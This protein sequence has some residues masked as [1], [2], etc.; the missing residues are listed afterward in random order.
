M[1]M[2]A[3]TKLFVT[4]MLVTVG[5]VGC[6]EPQKGAPGV[7]LREQMTTIEDLALRLDLRIVERDESFVVLKN[8][9]NTVIL[10]TNTNA[11]FFV[12][13][14]PVGSVG[15]VEKAGGTV[16]VSTMLANEIR[17]YLR[18]AAPQPSVV[19]PSR[20]PGAGAKGLVVIDAGHGGDDPGTI[21]L[22]HIYEKDINLEVARRVAALLEQRGV[23]VIMTRQQDR[24]VELEERAQIANRRNADLFVSIHSDSNPDRERQG[25]TVY[26]AKGASP[27]SYKAARAIN[28]AMGGTGSDSHG[29]READYR[30]L[31]QSTCPAV[32]VELG[33]LSNATE[34]RRLQ[35]SAYQTRLAQALA[36][37][38]SACLR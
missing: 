7:T 14:K 20:R 38:I 2:D 26:V 28:Q 1:N 27:D 18:P 17:P 24:F 3:R 6:Q 23:S 13:S 33:Y 34:A 36:D 30:V 32:L 5:L 16:Y 35:D 22:G 31:V 21:G 8:A 15:T 37:G 29:I 12:N 4:L 25:F 19:I 11:R 10:F 9:A